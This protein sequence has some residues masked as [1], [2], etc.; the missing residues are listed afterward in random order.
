MDTFPCLSEKIGVLLGPVGHVTFGGSI[1]VVDD[2]Q[3]SSF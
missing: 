3:E 1:A 2:G